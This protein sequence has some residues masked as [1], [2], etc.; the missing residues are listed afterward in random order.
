MINQG[1]ARRISLPL[2][3]GLAAWAGM[4]PVGTGAQ[5]KNDGNAPAPP[6]AL[7]AAAT[8]AVNA[9]KLDDLAPL[10]TEGGLP[11]FAWARGTSTKKWEGGILTPPGNPNAPN[12]LAVFHAWH[13][14]ESDG[15]H[16]HRLERTPQGWRLGPEIPETDTGGFRV[17]D[18]NL[19]ARFDIPNHA[20]TITD[21]AVIQRM[22]NVIPPF[23][24]LRLSDDFHV[25]SLA[26]DGQARPYQQVGGLIA[27]APPEA[28]R[29]TVS[30][31][32]A[33]VVNHQG[34]DYILAN[35][36]TLDSYW[37]PHIARL[38]ATATV[39]AEVP[40][41]WTILAQGEPTQAP[42]ENNGMVTATFRN[43]IPTCYFTLDAG[44]YTITTRQ[45]GGRTLATYF[46]KPNPDLAQKSLDTLEQAL[47]FYDKTFSRFP[48]TRYG[49]VETQG[50][51]QGALEAYSFSTYGP[52][53]LPET[54]P[55][56]LS[57]TW[58]GGVV[59]CAY[60]RSM[61]N[62]SFAEYS[63][64]L[65]HRM[66][67]GAQTAAPSR[68]HRLFPPTVFTSFPMTQAGDTSDNRQ[69]SVGYGKGPLALR[70]LEE[71]IGQPV[72]LKC[73]AA[74]VAQHTPGES[75]EWPEFEA[76]VKR[77]TGEDYRWFFAQWMERTGLPAL[78]LSGVAAKPD[79][80]ETLVEGDV[81]QDGTMPYRLR[82]PI[83]VEG[84]NGPLRTETLE[85]SAIATH[86]RL[87]IPLN[88]MPTRVRLDPANLLPLAAPA[89]TP[90]GANP[91][92]FEFEK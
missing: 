64:A 40:T 22:P 10:A 33:G 17:R 38:P 1:R 43:D 47:A 53:T 19:K 65:F 24:L 69:A 76:V 51:F 71:Q 63:D 61:W 72:M 37:Y 66:T 82:L 56:E 83:Q 49:V 30:L 52:G 68:P 79:G 4:C 2:L 54:I 50:S 62:E 78:R 3:M 35:E 12:Y 11:T 27:F 73:L 85:V 32:Y 15:D 90:A 91:T 55:H 86:F 9:R 75:A 58:W 81:V 48:Y 74:F 14:C 21:E 67:G 5:D 57:H 25:T 7:M 20:V 89:N 77:V 26:C 28:R 29:F 88:S 59:P 46:L 44:K 92:T 31:A 42:K 18:H 34:S 80:G 45:A 87:R 84:A 16:V 6:D 8:Q 36:A 70:V 60:T 41:G 23:V 13:T 39:Q